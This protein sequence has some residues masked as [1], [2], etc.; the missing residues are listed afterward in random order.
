MTSTSAAG[1]CGA[2]ILI[3]G[4]A[5]F[6]GSNLTNALLAADVSSIHIVDNL[7]SS[8]RW[9]VPIDSRVVFREGSIADD[10]ILNSLDDQYDFVF[11]LS[12][13]HGNQSSIHNPLADHENNQLTTLKLFERAK[14][15]KR[16]K[17][18]VYAGAGCRSL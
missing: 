6:V 4:G 2:S 10:L 8:E 11:H 16:L 12:T 9:N 7:L 1:F 3:T 14:S 15:F 13:Y 5:G 17:K 18:L